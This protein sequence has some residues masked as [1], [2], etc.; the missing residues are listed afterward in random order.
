[1]VDRG[2]Q[3]IAYNRSGHNVAGSEFDGMANGH[4]KRFSHHGV[5][6]VSVPT[7]EGKGLGALSSSF[8]ATL[9]AIKAKPDVIHYH[10]EGPCVMLRLAHWAGVRTVAT[11][12]GLDWQRAQWGK[13]AS[14]YLKFGE[15]TAAKCA[16]GIIVLSES[17]RQ[18]FQEKYGRSTHFIPNGIE[19]GEPLS[20]QEIT[21]KYG[22]HKNDYV[23]FLGHIVP[24][25]G[26]H[27]L[28]EAFS[29]L[30]TNKKLVI[31]GGASDSS[32]YYQHIQQMAN[33]DSR[34]ILIWFILLVRCICSIAKNNWVNVYI[35]IWLIL[36]I[37]D[38]YVLSCYVCFV[39]LFPLRAFQ[40]KDNH[41]SM[42]SA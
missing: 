28:I 32:E 24:E 10:A 23:L 12:Y 19:Y 26:V 7:I 22:L 11:I 20:A 3:V 40:A 2:H 5:N 38:V 25:K 39:A 35:I 31:A 27:Y 18:Y 34:V 30:N 1:M 17:M 4:S 36:G 16:D 9:Q 6:V 21:E 33:Q 8:F 42:F 13:F 15:R 37:T 41:D 29:K 14:A